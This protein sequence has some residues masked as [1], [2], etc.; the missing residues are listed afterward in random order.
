MAAPTPRAQRTRTL[1]F[2]AAAVAVAGFTAWL[3]FA[4]IA[5]Y[6]RQIEEAKSGPKLVGV[7]TAANELLP[8]KPIAEGDLVSAQMPEGSFPAEQIYTPDKINEIYGKM[9]VERVLPGEVLRHE[10]L[11]ILAAR[12]ALDRIIAPGARAVTVLAD[13]AA[14]VGGLLMPADQVDVIV[15]IR[16]DT[17][18]LGADWVTET[19]LQ[20][21]RVLAVDQDVLGG[22][23]EVQEEN[24]GKKSKGKQENRSNRKI[25][26]TI[27]VMP[28][29]AEKLALAAS[30]GDLH[31]TLRGSQDEEII[32]DRGPLVTNALLGLSS[33]GASDDAAARRKEVQ[34][35]AAKPK[36]AAATQTTATSTTEV[37]QGE[38]STTV[39][40]D[41]KGNKIEPK[42]SRG[43][44]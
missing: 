32:V 31:M 4:V 38:K 19:I 13:R 14:G 41:E 11:D 17:N 34:E 44:R 10:R 8:G 18:E 21:V 1:A 35:R 2:G 15:T 25:L 28:D 16:P 12:A 39:G 40:F 33:F 22:Q 36:P 9:P 23:A 27:E 3:I 24:S 37:I 43:G 6:Q 42:N 5:G 26:V 29:E 30:R 7:V 20:N